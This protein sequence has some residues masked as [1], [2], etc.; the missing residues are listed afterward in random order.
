M[1][2]I[3]FLRALQTDYNILHGFHL[4]SVLV[5][6]ITNSSLQHLYLLFCHLLN[7]GLFVSCVQLFDLEQRASVVI[8]FYIK[9]GKQTRSFT[10]TRKMCKGWL[11][12]LC[13]S[14]PMV[15]RFQGSRES[16][17]HE[18]RPGR[19]V[20]ARFNEYVDKP[21]AIV[22]QDRRMTT[23]L[24]AESLRVGKEA[25]RQIQERDL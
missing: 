21:H 10:N 3:I 20:S 13:T 5:S 16:M 8:T 15:R 23:K 2:P 19:N 9:L 14:L 25:P 24:L 6:M 17:E 4:Y 1:G 12:E 7:K 22:L 18:Y 11:P